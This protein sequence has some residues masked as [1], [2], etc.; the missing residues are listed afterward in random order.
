MFH[1]LCR[2]QIVFWIETVNSLDYQIIY[3][4]LTEFEFAQNNVEYLQIFIRKVISNTQTSE[5]VLDRSLSERYTL[6]G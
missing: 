5:K 6:S 1:R 4:G 3:S 2:H